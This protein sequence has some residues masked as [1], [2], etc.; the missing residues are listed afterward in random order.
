MTPHPQQMAE[1]KMMRE[2]G[3]I[4]QKTMILKQV[5]A[6]LSFPQ[7]PSKNPPCRLW[8]KLDYVRSVISASGI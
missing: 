1:E 7:S 5:P 2:Q 3:T 4:S 6:Q 8:T